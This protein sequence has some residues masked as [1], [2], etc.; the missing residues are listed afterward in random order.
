MSEG[1]KFIINM[2][3]DMQKQLD[4]LKHRVDKLENTRPNTLI[5]SDNEIE[6]TGKYIDNTINEVNNYFKE[7]KQ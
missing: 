2:L 3:K 1:E 7:E 6:E 5:I 4:D